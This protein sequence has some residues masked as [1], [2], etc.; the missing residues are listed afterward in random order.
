MT[1]LK[2]FVENNKQIIIVLY[3][4]LLI[5]L[6]LLH[7]DELKFGKI[8]KLREPF[9]SVTD[10]SNP[11]PTSNLPKP[12][13]ESSKP[14]TG[15]ILIHN[16]LIWAIDNDKENPD[17]PIKDKYFGSFISQVGSSNSNNN[18]IYTNS[19]PSDRW[20]ASENAEL[21]PKH[22]CID[23][24]Y[25]NYRRLMAIGMTIE[26][27]KPIYDIF[28]KYSTDFRSKWVKLES[29]KTIRSLCYDLKYGKLMGCSS[30]DGQI[31]E[32]K[33]RSLSYGNWIGPI[34][35]DTPMKKIM[36]DKEGYLI[37]IGLID[38]FIYRKK[39]IN[40]RDS[41]WDKQNINK[42]KVYDLIYDIDGCFIASTSEGIKKQLHPDFN[43]VFV[44]YKDFNQEHPTILSHDE[45]LQYKVGFEFLDDDFDTTTEL[46]RDLKRIYEFKKISNDLCRTKSMSKPQSDNINPDQENVNANTV[47]RQN[48]EINDLYS[49]IYSLTNKMNI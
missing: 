13:H 48:Q 8:L 14:D 41:K 16:L 29:N 43:S 26:N 9:Q 34:N 2:Q 18:F 28:K 39:T 40:W 20:M 1:N 37:G 44:N 25:D 49:E 35:Y 6:L 3:I 12:T 24:T 38:S 27:G 31:Y 45:I 11:S 30:Y 23:L 32:N 17:L 47:S 19:L 42:T 5:I 10:S 36:Y 22:I 15:S 21:S 46:G 7:I 33:F 4:V